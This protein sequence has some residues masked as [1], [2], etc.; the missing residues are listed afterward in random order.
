EDLFDDTS[1]FE[2]ECGLSLTQEFQFLEAENVKKESDHINLTNK[3]R[4][5]MISSK[6]FYSKRGDFKT[7]I[8]TNCVQSDCSSS[9]SECETS[10]QKRNRS[11]VG[12]ANVI[13]VA[14]SE[15]ELD[16][17]DTDNSEER[18][19]K[20][21][22]NV[23]S[24]IVVPPSDP[25]SEI[26]SPMLSQCSN[27]SPPLMGVDT[28]PEMDLKRKYKE[29]KDEN[30]NIITFFKCSGA[31]PK[32]PSKRITSCSIV[33]SR[34]P[35]SISNTVN[36]PSLIPRGSLNFHKG[37][38][39][40]ASQSS[41]G[42]SVRSS[43]SKRS[44]KLVERAKLSNKEN[45]SNSLSLLSKTPVSQKQSFTIRGNLSPEVPPPAVPEVRSTSSALK[46]V[47]VPK[48]QSGPNETY[49][50]SDDEPLSVIRRRSKLTHDKSSNPQSVGKQTKTGVLKRCLQFSSCIILECAEKTK[51]SSS[52]INLP[53]TTVVS[54]GLSPIPGI[55]RETE[56]R[57]TRM[58][59]RPKKLATN[60]YES[61]DSEKEVWPSDHCSYRSSDDFKTLASSTGSRSVSSNSSGDPGKTVIPL[62]KSPRPATNT[63][64]KPMTKSVS[65]L[66]PVIKRGSKQKKTVAS[67]YDVDRVLEEDVDDPESQPISPPPMHSRPS[68]HSK[69]MTKGPAT[70]IIPVVNR[71]ES[72]QKKKPAQPVD[73]SVSRP[74]SIL[75]QEPNSS[76]KTGKKL[77]GAAK[78]LHSNTANNK[79]KTGN[80]TPG[81]VKEDIESP[82]HSDHVLFT[83]PEVIKE[84]VDYFRYFFDTE[85]MDLIVE[86]TNLYIHQDCGETWT[87][88]K[89]DINVFLGIL[90]YMG[91]CS[92]PGIRDYWAEYTLVKQVADLMPR[93]KFQKIR[94]HIHFND[95]A[96]VDP[97][98]TDR[99]V[100]IR[101]LI[102]IFRM[103]CQLLEEEA[104]QCV[105]ECMVGYKGKRAGAARQYMPDK[106][107]HKWGFKIFSRNGKSGLIYDFI[108]YYGSHTFD[109]EHPSQEEINIGSG[110]QAVISFCKSI[111]HPSSTTVTFDNYYTGLIPLL[112]YLKDDMNILSLGTVKANR[113]GKCPL[114]SDAQLADQ[115]R[116]SYDYRKNEDN[117][118]VVKWADNK[119]V[120]LAST[121]VGLSP[122][123]TIPRYDANEHQKV[124]VPCPQIVLA[125]NSSMGGTDLFDQYMS[126]YRIPSRARRWY[127]PLFVFLLELALINSFLLYKREVE[128]IDAELKYPTLKDFRLQVFHGLTA[129]A[130]AGRG[131]PNLDK[132]L[133]KK[134]AKRR[135][136]KHGVSDDLR[137][138]NIGHF[139]SRTSRGRC[140]YCAE[141]HTF[142][143]CPKCDKRLCFTETRNCF[144]Q[145]HIVKVLPQCKPKKKNK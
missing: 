144:A 122:M 85:V 103:K 24:D 135:I 66:I 118:F 57:G 91:I 121:K 30:A 119:C 78:G 88:T 50:D 31:K 2:M 4:K 56:G 65:S 5:T 80:D 22:T 142:S 124:P 18:W 115:G 35:L 44:L 49:S 34:L 20:S 75:V 27:M 86:Q 107:S 106:P 63:K 43:P 46:R 45:N 39:I 59:L 92:L 128:L 14:D 74:D 127:F 64:T 77:K 126:L 109:N 13:A 89:D 10:V 9:D 6:L 141:G 112:K 62:P 108:P 21:K 52:P 138:D 83:M 99:M 55:C 73:D 123:G 53:S 37:K 7:C 17:D 19:S 104:D 145:F 23:V 134:A 28:S 60:N 25:S 94:S 79:K 71:R 87:V 111:K 136:P 36:K 70:S 8:P 105:D 120:C 12:N 51:A 130:L 76:S 113:T 48:V 137:T 116:G 100:K 95:N 117:I 125:Y 68:H 67:V 81:W 133:L 54:P 41:K 69:P 90:I 132:S 3:T 16:S 61:S 101:P 26:S 32:L 29:S 1:S 139:I 98:D 33:P 84:P 72:Q 93:A 42:L 96:S 82:W 131:R 11:G 40:S 102:K 47:S 97:E 114:M 110:A 15:S 129:V 140:T 143:F 38:E 58:S